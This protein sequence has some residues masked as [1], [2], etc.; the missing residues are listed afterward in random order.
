MEKSLGKNRRVFI[1]D[2]EG[3]ETLEVQDE[4]VRLDSG[5]W[6][7]TKCPYPCQSGKKD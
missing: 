2:S 6:K 7:R 3:K 4:M 1:I 5:P